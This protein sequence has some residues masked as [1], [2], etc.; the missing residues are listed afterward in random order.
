[1]P[2]LLMDEPVPVRKA[3]MGMVPQTNTIH[4]NLFPP[5]YINTFRTLLLLAV[6]NYTS[7]AIKIEL[8]ALSRTQLLSKD[9]QHM[10]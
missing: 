10:C 5:I 8:E 4:P 6:S 9:L 7:V 3:G 2:C 1:M